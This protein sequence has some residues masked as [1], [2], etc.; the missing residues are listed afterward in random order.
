M[1]VFICQTTSSGV[2]AGMVQSIFTGCQSL[3]QQTWSEI[4]QPCF[5]PELLMSRTTF[6]GTTMFLQPE[7]TQKQQLSFT[8]FLTQLY[9]KNLWNRNWSSASDKILRVLDQSIMFSA[10]SPIPKR[11]HTKVPG[12]TLLSFSVL[13]FNHSCTTFK[14]FSYVSVLLKYIINQWCCTFKVDLSLSLQCPVNLSLVL[15]Q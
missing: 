8:P 3:E 9:N 1:S 7:H 2:I 4:L 14:Q 6:Q 15:S 12:Q 5:H 11:K 10:A 13:T